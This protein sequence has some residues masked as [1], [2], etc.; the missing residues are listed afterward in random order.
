MDLLCRDDKLNISANYLKPGFAYGGSCLPKDLRAITHMARQRGVAVPVLDAIATSNQ[1]HV[2]QAIEH[3]VKSGKTRIGLLG[4][5]FKAGTDDLRESPMISLTEALLDEGFEVRIY[6]E[7]VSA[8]KR[9]GAN[10]AYIGEEI[11]HI[12]SRLCE[13]I[14]EVV[15]RS[16][17]V[18]VGN[19]AFAAAVAAGGDR[20]VYDLV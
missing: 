7:Y 8:A 10:R 13:S 2:D 5:T 14:E 4:L 18:V 6:D 17:L 16:E 12:S 9:A 1:I 11:P 19:R 20:L 15:A 3:I